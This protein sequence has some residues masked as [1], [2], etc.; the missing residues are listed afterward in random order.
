MLEKKLLPGNL[1]E[2]ADRKAKWLALPRRARVAIR[3]LHRNFKHLP[4][5]ALVQML[6]A[7][8]SPKECI[9][10]AKSY[11][12]NICDQTKKAPPTHKVGMP[13]PYEF[14]VEVGVDVVEIKDIK[15]RIY[16]VLNVVDYGTTFEQAFIVREADIHGSPSSQSCLEQFT[17]GWVR[18]FG[19]PKSVAID[20]GTHNRGVFNSTLARKG[21]RFNPVGLESPE[22]IGRV[23][24]RNQNP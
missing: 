23:E 3:R 15:G 9:D 19:W 20:R 7:S 8:K 6:R 1:V 14:N 22:Q 21:V 4:K 24:G 10:A 2:E 16:D 17:K 12:C 18:P 11:R 5:T 13:K